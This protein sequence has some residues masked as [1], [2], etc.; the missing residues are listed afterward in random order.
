MTVLRILLLI[1]LLF[2]T[3]DY[4]APLVVS[5]WGVAVWWGLFVVIL[6][7]GYWVWAGKRSYVSRRLVLGYLLLAAALL[8][9]DIMTRLEQ[10]SLAFFS[11]A[12]IV[13]AVYALWLEFDSLR[14]NHESS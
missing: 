5:R 9:H 8:V 3:R 12:M 11:V 4:L 6:T 14:Q 13:G 10:P 2:G 1:L 7:S